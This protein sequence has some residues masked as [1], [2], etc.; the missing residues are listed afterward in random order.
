MTIGARNKQAGDTV[1]QNT[2]TTM[3]DMA[4]IINA[5]SHLF[6]CRGVFHIDSFQRGVTIPHRRKKQT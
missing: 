2:R 6:V 4:V 3:T 1:G 5:K